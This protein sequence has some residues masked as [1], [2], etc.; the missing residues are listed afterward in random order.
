MPKAFKLEVGELPAKTTMGLYD[1]IIADFVRQVLDNH[2]AEHK[3]AKVVIPDR[4]V[5]TVQI[6]LAKAV[7]VAKRKDIMVTIRDGAVWLT[8]R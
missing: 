6:G 3:S 5:K 7:S 1:T 4:K 8:K 2:D